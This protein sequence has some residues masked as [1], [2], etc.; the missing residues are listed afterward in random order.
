MLSSIQFSLTRC[1][2]MHHLSLVLWCKKAIPFGALQT[3]WLV[4]SFQT[5]KLQSPVESVI[6]LV[7][8][9]ITK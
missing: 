9:H 5:E 7:V 3:S 8:Y 4:S 2:I 6:F 1:F